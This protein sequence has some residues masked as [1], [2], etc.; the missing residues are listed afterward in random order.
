MA[1]TIT[2]RLPWPPSVNSYIR[3]TGNRS[4]ITHKGRAYRGEVSNVVLNEETIGGALRGRLALH[5]ELIPPD[6]RRR[7]IDNHVKSLVDAMMHAG[8]FQD[9]EQI[10][11]LRVNRLHVE[12]P[13]CADVTIHEL[14]DNG[15][16]H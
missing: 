12:S 14:T 13:G 3:H 15:Q 7:D 4:Y 5:I 9:D 2:Y 8:V 10:D 16:Q 1:T 11:E 6:R